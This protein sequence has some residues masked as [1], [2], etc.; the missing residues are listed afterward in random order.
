MWRARTR[1]PSIPSARS[2]RRR[3]VCSAPLASAAWRPPSTIYIRRHAA[4]VEGRLA[5]ELDLNPAFKAVDRSHQ[6]M[7]GVVVGRRP[8]VRGDLVLVIPGADRQRVADE[9][10]SGRSL[11][12]RCQDVRARLVDPRRRVVDPEGPEPKASTLP[13]KQAA[14]HARRIEAG[15]AEP[16]DRPIGGHER[17]GAAVGQERVIGDRRERR[18]CGRTLLLGPLC[19]LAGRRSDLGDAHAVT[20]RPWPAASWSAAFGG[21]H[22]PGA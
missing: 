3:I 20:Q 4:V 16:V 13:V 10:P 9:N 6:H 18:G 11:P 14:K 8:G 5:D 7:V 2:E 15:H 12:R 17:A 1:F 21:P 22:D 19:C